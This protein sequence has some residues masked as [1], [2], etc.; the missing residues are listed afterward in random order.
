[1]GNRK[2]WLLH[3]GAGTNK[4]QYWIGDFDGTGT[5]DGADLATLLG[6]WGGAGGDLDDDEFAGRP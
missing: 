3:S 1:M 6:A 5:V 2:K 4:V